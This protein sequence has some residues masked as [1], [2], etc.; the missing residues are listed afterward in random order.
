MLRDLES[1]LKIFSVVGTYRYDCFLPLIPSNFFSLKSSMFVIAVLYSSGKSYLM[2]L[3][4]GKSDGFA[5][6]PG[7][8]CVF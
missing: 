8:V 6:G 4:F 3:L 7:T 1:T 5:L 2:N